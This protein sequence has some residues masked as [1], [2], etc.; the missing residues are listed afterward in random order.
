LLRIRLELP[1]AEWH[2]FVDGQG[3][4]AHYGWM[5]LTGLLLVGQRRRRRECL[6]DLGAGLSV[7][8]EKAWREFEDEVDRL[9]AAAN[10]SRSE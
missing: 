6:I 7:F 9:T 3:V 5:R 8:P 1:V 4:K 10:P 2:E